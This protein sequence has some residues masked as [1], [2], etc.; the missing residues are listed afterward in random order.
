MEETQIVEIWDL[1]VE[2]I[3]EKHRETLALQYIEYLLDSGVDVDDLDS[4]VGHD[5]YL[6]IAIEEVTETLQEEDEYYEDE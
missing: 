5:D 1:F 2:H 4:I 3:P 6:D